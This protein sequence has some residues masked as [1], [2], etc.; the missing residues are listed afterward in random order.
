MIRSIPC[1][2]AFFQLLF[3]PAVA[4]NSRGIVRNGSI[5][6]S[7]NAVTGRGLQKHCGNA[8]SGR[9]GMGGGDGRRFAT[10]I[11]TVK[12]TNLACGQPL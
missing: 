7:D 10:K 12:V 6:I 11:A 1:V 8:A 3:A 9:M 5:Q 4:A 2:V